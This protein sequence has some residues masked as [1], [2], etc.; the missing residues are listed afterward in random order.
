M[1]TEYSERRVS[2]C[3]CGAGHV[4]ERFWANDHG[5]ASD[6]GWHFDYIFIDCGTCSK[7]WEVLGRPQGK[8]VRFATREE[9]ESVRKHNDALAKESSKLLSETFALE[10][11]AEKRLQALQREL[12]KKAESAGAGVDPKFEAVGKAL[13]FDSLSK[14]K[15]EVGRTRPQTYVPRLVTRETSNK[16][17]QNLGR[18]DE[19]AKARAITK[20]VQELKKERMAVEAKKLQPKAA[21]EVPAVADPMPD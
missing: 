12:V 5:F 9:S 17:L 8:T 19:V 18:A 7:K 6:Y 20:K 21:K 3:P 11:E 10:G 16:V 1:G 13:G 4:K 2:A 15:A 14:F